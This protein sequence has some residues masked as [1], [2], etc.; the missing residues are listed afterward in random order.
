M[1]EPTPPRLEETAGSMLEL[2]RII[3]FTKDIERMAAFYEDVIGLRRLET[4]DDP[5]D[6]I[7][8]DGGGSQLALHAIPKRYARG[9]EI[10]D[11]PAPRE[12]TP[13]KAV[14]RADD[15]EAARAQLIERGATMGPFKAF[16]DLHLCNGI[17]T[18][19]NVFQISNRA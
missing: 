10:S 7:S 2:A 19:G 18:E 15:V 9:I 8:F 16:G 13:L 6:F 11:P 3:I 1:A 5:A 17:D 12:D 4:E 14:F